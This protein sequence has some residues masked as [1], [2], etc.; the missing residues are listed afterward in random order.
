M[1]QTRVG[2]GP[3]P[4]LDQGL[5]ILCPGIPG[6]YCEWSEPCTGGLEPVPGVRAHPWRFWTLLG[7]PVRT[8][9]GPALSHGVR[10][11]C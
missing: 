9:R 1:V 7:G 3:P 10:T 5:G 2:S 8:Y 11:H 6:P 4:D